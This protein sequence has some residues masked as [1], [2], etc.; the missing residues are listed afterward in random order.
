M[1]KKK[2]KT[3]E[4]ITIICEGES[5][6]SYIKGLLTEFKLLTNNIEIIRIDGGGYSSARNYL[7]KNKKIINIALVVMD[8]D[9]CSSVSNEKKKLKSLIL[10]LENLNGKN[11][12]FL[13]YPNFEAWV[14]ACLNCDESDLANKGYKKGNGVYKFIRNNGGSYE[15]ALKIFENNGLYYEKKSINKGIYYEEN[16]KNKHSSLYYFIDYLKFLLER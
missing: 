15:N 13:T 12:I 4:K 3:T 16:I 11:N 7:M 8:L 2:L 1:S 14:A 9:R 6:E 10:L 5:E